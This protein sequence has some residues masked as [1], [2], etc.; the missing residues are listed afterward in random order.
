MSQKYGYRP[1][2]RTISAS[3]FDSLFAAIEDED[4]KRL[5]QVWF[6]LDDNAIPPEYVLQLISSQFPDFLDPPTIEAR[7]H[8][9]KEWWDVFLSLQNALRKAAAKTLPED[10]AHKYLQSGNCYVLERNYVDVSFTLSEATQEP[11]LLANH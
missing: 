4:D 3:E 11:Y 5:L 7:Q 10:A 9:L 8:A 6:K 1:F 2:P